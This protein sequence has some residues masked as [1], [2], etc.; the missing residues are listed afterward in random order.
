MSWFIPSRRELEQQQWRY[1]GRPYLGAVG[2]A[3]LLGGGLGVCW[4]LAG[5]YHFHV[6][7]Y[8]ESLLAFFR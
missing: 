3:A 4:I 1:V 7:P 6:R 8:V 2:I 5:L